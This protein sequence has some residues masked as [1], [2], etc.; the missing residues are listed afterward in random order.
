M[1]NYIGVD[2]GGTNVRVAKVNQDGLV[3]QEIKEAS[4]VSM[5]TKHVMDKIKRMIKEI[6]NYQTCKGIG[7]GVPGPVDTINGKMVI[8][9][10]LP[11]FEDYPIVKD[12][13]DYFDMPT[14]LDNDVNVAGLAEAVV[15]AGKN[16]PIVFYASV[17]TGIGG[18]LCIN[19][20]VIAGKRGHAGEI[21]NISIDRTREAFNGLVKGAA[22][23][24]ASGTALT[25]KG[26]AALGEN[27]NDAGDVFK[28]AKEGNER[29][30]KLVDDFAYDFAMML[31]AIGH[32]V[33]PNMFI[34]GGGVMKSKDAFFD[35]MVAYYKTLVFPGMKDVQFSEAALPEPGLIG[36]A[37]LP[38]SNEC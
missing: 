38:M 11:G 22:E 17:S 10:N 23:N 37:M 4:E 6:D 33:D 8:A 21:G 12:I 2:L 25:R 15:G 18:A 34:I 27:I 30:I 24:E 26:K 7:L 13:S 29:A 5:G 35:K 19:G 20:H 9:N 1:A 16:L 14:Y 28:L 31:A 32:V 3:L 36:A